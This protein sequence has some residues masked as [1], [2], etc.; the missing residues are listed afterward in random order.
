MPPDKIYTVRHNGKIFDIKGPPGAT[1]EQLMAALGKKAPAA[2][3]P[4]EPGG[5]AGDMVKQANEDLATG[6]Q[7]GLAKSLTKT[8][9]GVATTVLPKVAETYLE[10]KG[11]LPTAEDV[12]LLEAGTEGS[13]AAQI[14]SGAIDV[15]TDLLPYSKVMKGVR[16]F[17]AIPRGMV[18]GG[19]LA[20]VRAEG[21]SAPS[22]AVSF[23]CWVQ[24]TPL[25]T[26]TYAEP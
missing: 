10:A 23:A 14:A 26:K 21:D 19:T 20:G 18:L 1:Q 8:V 7:T 12:K 9:R 13:T 24:V 3:K 6:L 11:I 2:P 25:R 17:D 5:V 22:E 4:V 15:A 16:G